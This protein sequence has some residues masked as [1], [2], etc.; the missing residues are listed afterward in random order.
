MISLTVW[1]TERGG[2]APLTPVTRLWIVPG[3]LPL[4]NRKPEPEPESETSFLLVLS[5]W[6]V[7]GQ[8]TKS[9]G[10]PSWPGLQDT[11]DWTF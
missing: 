11:P 10:T 5:H 7:A 8:K 2:T 6:E 3:R 9:L 1:P 4:P